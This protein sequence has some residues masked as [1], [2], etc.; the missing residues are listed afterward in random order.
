[1]KKLSDLV[2]D[3]LISKKVNHVFG[4][5]GGGAMHLND[6]IGK[7][8]KIN[9]ILHHHEQA[10]T[11]AAEAYSR[12]KKKIG[13]AHVTT[14]PGGTNAITGLVGAWID[15]IPML[16]ISGQ[17]AKKDMINKTK[18]RQIGVQEINIVDLVK[19]VTKYAK[20]IINP[21]DIIFELS[22][23]YELAVSGR[24]GPVW[25]D[26]PL[27]IQSYRINISKLKKIPKIK[28]KFKKIKKTNFNFIVKTLKNKKFPIFLLGNGIHLSKAEKNI[29][30]LLKRIK[31]PVLTSWNASDLVNFNDETYIGRAGLFGDRASN[32]TIQN[33]DL[34]FVIGSR[35]SQPQVGYNL[36]NFAINSKI[37]YLDIDKWEINKFKGKIIKSLNYDISYFLKYFNNYL[38]KNKIFINKS[39]WLNKCNFWKRKYPV[40][41]Y[42]YKKEKK[43]N[44]F[45][46]IDTLSSLLKKKDIIVTDMGTSFTCTMQTFKT[47][48]KQ[49]LFTSS[50]LA[51][52]GFGLPGS[53]G[54]CFANE[55]KKIICVSG[56][57]GIMFNLQELQT[58][59]HHKLPIKLFILC[60]N[61][62]LTMKLMQSK[63]FKKYIGSNPKSGLSCPNFEKIA[64][65]F[66]I[67][68]ITVKNSNNLKK[69]IESFIKRKGPGVCQIFMRDNQQ[70]I[71]RVQTKMRKDGTFEPTPIDD[72]YPYLEREEYKNNILY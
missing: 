69:K 35:L 59:F 15:S 9:F 61:G 7:N 6:S 2:V 21:K 14:G 34:I 70:L 71:P 54:A 10:A 24:P 16:V 51:A 1:M 48:K 45:Y 39:E 52:M 42:K 49:R 53:I 66:S 12:V 64:R 67:N 18:T 19:P 55:K 57:G 33:S 58:I 30:L 56:D 26:I 60:N 68:S 25:I 29:E 36:S 8:K 65:S 41:L 28:N 4:V 47:K 63:N 27:D 62:Y 3:F 5:T 40:V 50:G 31:I 32:F 72:M 44:S 22:K 46:F 23:A 13:V 17:V 20:T 11:M 38:K 43:I 37:I